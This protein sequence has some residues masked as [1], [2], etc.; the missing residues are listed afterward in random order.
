VSQLREAFQVVTENFED[1][2]NLRLYVIRG[3]F[4][5]AIELNFAAIPAN[6]IVKCWIRGKGRSAVYDSLL[7]EEKKIPQLLATH[8]GLFEKLW[9]LAFYRAGR[10]DERIDTV[11]LSSLLASVCTDRIFALIPSTAE[12][13][14]WSQQLLIT[15]VLG[16]HFK[17]EPTPER[18][19]QFQQAAPVFAQ[20]LCVPRPPKQPPPRDPLEDKQKLL[21]ALKQGKENP[22]AQTWYMLRAVAALERKIKHPEPATEEEVLHV[23][24]RIAPI[25]KRRVLEVFRSCVARVRY[26]H[27][28]TSRG[29]YSMT[30]EEYETPFET[31]QG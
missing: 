18:L 21:N 8:Q 2:G 1:L 22:L 4:S 23:L 24:A 9:T 31:Q 3:L 11:D 12:R 14:T 25:A 10:E 29:E 26:K 16:Q 20:R 6:L 30:I 5:R 17:K 28:R 27:E 15:N 13:L 7:R 19:L